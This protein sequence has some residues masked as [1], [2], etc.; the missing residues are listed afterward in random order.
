[1]NDFTKEMRG[2]L[3]MNDKKEPEQWVI[4]NQ[5][6]KICAHTKILQH[7]RVEKFDALLL[8]CKKCKTVWSLDG[9]E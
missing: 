5:Q 1:M 7:H 3:Q 8:S 2:V 9:D 6:S 4:L